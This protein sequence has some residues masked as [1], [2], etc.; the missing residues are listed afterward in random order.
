M[1]GSFSTGH[2]WN[3]GLT[4]L[5]SKNGLEYARD[6]FKITLLEYRPMK[7]DDSTI[8]ERENYW[9]EVLLSRGTF[10]YNKN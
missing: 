2:G 1:R 5:I 10:G 4:E 3:D 6:H 7:T 9:K 8:I